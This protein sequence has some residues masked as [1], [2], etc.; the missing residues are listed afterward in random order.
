MHLINLASRFIFLFLCRPLFCTQ[1]QE[2]KDTDNQGERVNKPT[3]DVYEICG[4]KRHQGR[5]YKVEGGIGSKR[6]EGHKWFVCGKQG[7]GY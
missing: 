1:K 7:R 2:D 3:K 6:I 5:A 4:N